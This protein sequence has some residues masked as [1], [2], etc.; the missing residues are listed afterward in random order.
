MRCSPWVSDATSLSLHSWRFMSTTLAT[1]QKNLDQITQRIELACERS[2]RDRTE[3]RV[4]GVTKYAQTEWVREL[5]ELGWTTLGEARPQQLVERAEQF[6]NDPDMPAVNWHLIG[7]LQRNKVRPILPVV[8]VIHSVDSLR[9]LDRIEFIADELGTRPRV[10]LEVNIAEDSAKDGFSVSNLQREW[11]ELV[12]RSAVQIEGLMTMAPHTDDETLI[13]RTFAQ[14][15][16]L[17]DQ[18]RDQSPVHC[19]LDELSMGMSGDFEIAIEEGSTMIRLGSALFE[20]L[21]DQ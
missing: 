4:I 3:V 21:H 20:G 13:R 14:L 17:R 15:R 7:H 8:E 10:L 2:N 9:L 16:E 6:H 11:P 5:V 18:L 19:P 1:L 12:D